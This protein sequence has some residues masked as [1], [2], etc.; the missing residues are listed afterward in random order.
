MYV[1]G[2]ACAGSRVPPSNL[3]FWLLLDFGFSFVSGLRLV[4]GYLEP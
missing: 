3:T 2:R 1:V 4:T